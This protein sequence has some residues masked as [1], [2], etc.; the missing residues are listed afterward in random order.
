MTENIETRVCIWKEV[1]NNDKAKKQAG[2]YCITLGDDKPCH[3]CDGTKEYADKIK[4]NLYKVL[5][6]E[7][8]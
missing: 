1:S 3:N 2:D 7:R 6:G 4:C 8:K 5:R